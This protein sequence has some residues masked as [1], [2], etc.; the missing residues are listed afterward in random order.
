MFLRPSR[1]RRLLRSYQGLRFTTFSLPLATFCCPSGASRKF[2]PWLISIVPPGLA[3]IFRS[4][5]A[6]AEN[7]LRTA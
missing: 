6:R 3:N 4:S 5:G 1:A 7:H 2:Y